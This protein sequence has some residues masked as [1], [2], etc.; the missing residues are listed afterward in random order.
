MDISTQTWLEQ[1]D[2]YVST[3]IRKHGWCIQYVGG[4]SCSRPGCECGPDDG[5]PIAYTIGLFGLG[6]PEL[7]IL[8]APPPTAGRVL[9]T[10]GNRIRA[11]TNLIHG[12][13][14]TFED[15]P[16]RIICEQV[17]NP[18]EIVY[19]ANRHY[20]RPSEASVP[21][22]QLSYDDTSGRFPWDPGY[23]APEMQPRPGNFTA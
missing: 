1:E 6:H 10:L 21:V 15:W 11:G 7:L 3:T 22:L 9:N 2:A 17:P 16:H 5:P 18:G 8:G 4:D 12:Q 20:Q 19:G 14:V 23:A 13:L